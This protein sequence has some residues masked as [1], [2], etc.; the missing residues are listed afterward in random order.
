MKILGSIWKNQLTTKLNENRREQINL[1]FS[2]TKYCDHNFYLSI[3]KYQSNRPEK[4]YSRIAFNEY[5]AFL[6]NEL[7]ENKEQLFA[8]M[9]E[10]QHKISNALYLLS[11]INQYWW[12]D[13]LLDMDEHDLVRFCDVTLHSTY[14]KL[15]EGI[16]FHF[17]YLLA[18]T[19]RSARGKADEGLD[20]YNCV[21]EIER[22]NKYHLTKP[23]SNTVRNGI[24]HGGIIYHQRKI[25]YTDKKGN[26]ADLGIFEV[27]ELV[28]DL[29]DYCNGI[30][31]ATKLFY[32]QNS[33][34][35]IRVPQ[36]LMIEELQAEADSPW[37][38]IEGCLVS[39][40]DTN[41]QL[42]IYVKS[43][44]RDYL[45]VFFSAF[46]TGVLSEYFSP[47]YD[48]YFLHIRSNIAL[49]GW[50]SFNGPKLYE[51]R[52]TEPKSFDDY[53]PALENNLIFY[54][55]YFKLPRWLGWIDT[56]LHS[57]RIN[58][59]L[60]KQEIQIKQ[61]T[62]Q[63]TVRNV[64]IHRNGWRSVLRGSIVFDCNDNGSIQSIVRN[65]C[66]RIIKET[67]T[68]ASNEAS[69]K[70]SAKY[71]PLGYARIFVFNKDYRKRKLIKYGLNEDLIGTIE[72]NKIKRIKAPDING[73]TI[74]T[75]GS[76]RIA[77]NRRWLEKFQQQNRQS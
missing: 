22:S 57:F 73:S 30:A 23:Y 75:L 6:S 8:L 69:V 54:A 45:K 74:E 35:G 48:R 44:T 24:A 28:D 4:Y 5:S 51:I 63:F 36:Q 32:I 64:Q 10:Q 15:I 1:Q 33:N 34:K 37:W 26:T 2:Q 55:P 13:S 25:R 72:I 66:K 61:G 19:L 68:K 65:S 9:D 20:V 43:Y 12:H 27:I 58:W 17:L 49:P 50:A 14:L 11:E 29:L 53:Y 60:I 77:W 59:P 62:P 52:N 76:Y 56:F 3:H 7:K 41:K 67:L 71:I 16:Y 38:H 39:E 21:E 40:F 46:L 18:A 42:I 70:N 47:G 31:L